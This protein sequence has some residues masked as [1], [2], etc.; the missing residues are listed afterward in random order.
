MPTMPMSSRPTWDS[1]PSRIRL[2]RGG[3][4][5]G[6]ALSATVDGPSRPVADSTQSRPAR[7]DGSGPSGGGGCLAVL[8]DLVHVCVLLAGVSPILELR[9]A[10]H[11]EPLAQP[12]VVGVEQAE[13]LAVRND[14]REQQLL[15]RVLV[16]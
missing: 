4:P 14:L 5:P 13:L 16:L 10:E 9:H 15:E 3:W 7:Q 6:A 1:K 8:R 2:D 11:V 12:A